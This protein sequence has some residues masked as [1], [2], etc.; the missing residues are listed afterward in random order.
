MGAKG[1]CCSA[2][3]KTC[4]LSP[5][6]QCKKGSS[7]KIFKEDTVA[8]SFFFCS[9]CSSSSLRV[10]EISPVARGESM[11]VER[12]TSSSSRDA[13]KSTQIRRPDGGPLSGRQDEGCTRGCETKMQWRTRVSDANR[14]NSYRTRTTRPRF[15]EGIRDK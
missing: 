8:A 1:C 10:F 6:F 7:Q 2:R 12:M 3:K 13:R 4:P 15:S 9:S 5:L 14:G 11:V